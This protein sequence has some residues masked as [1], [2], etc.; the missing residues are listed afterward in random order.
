VEI[1]GI[2]PAL[3]SFEAESK[4]KSLSPERLAISFYNERPFL[5]PHKGVSGFLT[6]HLN[7][8]AAEPHRQLTL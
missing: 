7:V 3:T 2:Q 1:D 8:Q 6:I 4:H 5:D